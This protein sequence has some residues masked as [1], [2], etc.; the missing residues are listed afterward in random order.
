[1]KSEDHLNREISSPVV[2]CVHNKQNETEDFQSS[3]R[4][5]GGSTMKFAQ[6]NP[7]RSLP[8]TVVY[9]SQLYNAWSRQIAEDPMPEARDYILDRLKLS[10]IG[11]FSGHAVRA[12]K[13]THCTGRAVNISDTGSDSIVIAKTTGN[14]TSKSLEIRLQPKLTVG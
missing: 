2:G 11:K 6:N 5:G 4:A 8:M 1:M 7:P 13:D 3:Y 14:I 9:A 10:K 12:H